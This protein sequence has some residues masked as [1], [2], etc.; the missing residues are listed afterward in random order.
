MQTERVSSSLATR[1]S[2]LATPLSVFAGDGQPEAPAGPPT[3]QMTLWE[4]FQVST[5]PQMAAG[6]RE[7]T[8]EEYRGL[9]RPGGLWPRLT[10]DPPVCRVGK[11]TLAIFIQRLKQQPGRKE[12]RLSAARVW[13]LTVYVD[14]VLRDAAPRC[15]F[16]DSATKR[17]LFGTDEDGDPQFAPLCSKLDGF[18]APQQPEPRPL[19]MTELERVLDWLSSDEAARRVKSPEGHCPPAAWWHAL[20]LTAYLTGQRRGVL[21]SFL[22]E[23]PPRPG[24]ASSEIE[25]DDEGRTYVTTPADRCK[26]HRKSHHWYLPPEALQAI[27]SLHAEGDL[28][29]AYPRTAV[30]FGR[31]QK[32]IY[33]WAGVE[34][35]GRKPCHC[36]RGRFA[37][38]MARISE[39]AATKQ[40]G[41][42][43][44]VA[45]SNYQDAA[46]I[47]EASA[48]MPR[49][50]R[51]RAKDAPGQKVLF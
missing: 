46:L 43:A 9:L 25:R 1:H 26:G 23:R 17:G 48:Q 15:Q 37:T 34:L 44:A 7:A 33:I 28:C 42:A 10:G 18:F 29:F 8:Y 30:Q 47:A 31:Y 14:K 38:E 21:V 4:V 36:L 32:R 24:L 5:W 3:P 49:P 2:P 40:C 16:A 51:R 50:G 12:K 11:A 13:T 35:A 6:C 27:Q 39:S 20:F 19:K 22:G 41:H 45:R